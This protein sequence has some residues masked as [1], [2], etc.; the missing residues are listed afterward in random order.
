MEKYG[1][2]SVESGDIEAKNGPESGWIIHWF[3]SDDD[4]FSGAEQSS[5]DSAGG[6]HRLP[7]T[8]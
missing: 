4:F 6:M 7:N 8:S 1:H 5:V 2:Q 3:W